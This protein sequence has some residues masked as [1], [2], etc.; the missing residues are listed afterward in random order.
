MMEKFPALQ[1]NQVTL[2]RA[3]RATG[4]VLDEDL[5]LAISELQ[6]VFTV[7]SDLN[8]AIAAAQ[9]IIIA[10]VG[11]ECVIQNKE[12]VTLEVLTIENIHNK[13]G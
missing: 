1:H 2:L 12:K 8:A 3:E 13:K 10:N 9:K 4:H 6:K 5:E 11:I 7:F